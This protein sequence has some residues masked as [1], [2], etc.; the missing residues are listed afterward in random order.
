MND[1]DRY[2]L[3]DDD[4][5]REMWLRVAESGKNAKD[6]DQYVEMVNKLRDATSDNSTAELH[7]NV[8]LA[9]F[10]RERDLP[11]KA[12]AYMDKTAFIPENTWWIIGP[13]DNAAGIGYNTVYIPEDTT[14]ID[15]AAQYNGIDGQVKWEK[16][17]DDTFDGYIDL[18]KIFAKNVNW[19]TVY[20]WTI[21]NSPNERKI[22]LRFG[23]GTQSKLW[24]NGEE[25]F[26]HS[27]SHSI[28]MDQDTIPVT[29]KQGENS[30]LVKVC[31][32]D[33]YFMGFYLRITD[34]D[35]KPFDDLKIGGSH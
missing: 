5:T 6:E 30:I 27:D 11:E 1:M 33:T 35:G 16:Q 15:P 9:R 8:T 26:T 4:M 18:E 22:E 21:V 17:A 19:N 2:Y 10:Y 32:E 34:T 23:S 28:A 29:L 3:V 12:E 25:V 14:Q 7:A 13:F 20:A 24:L 31:S